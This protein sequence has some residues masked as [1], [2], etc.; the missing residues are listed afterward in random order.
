ME[1]LNWVTVYSQTEKRVDIISTPRDWKVKH[2]RVLEGHGGISP[3][4]RGMGNFDEGKDFFI[5]WWKSV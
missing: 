5:G 3:P 2:A 1:V 4:S